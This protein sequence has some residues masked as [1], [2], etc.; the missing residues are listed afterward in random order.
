MLFKLKMFKGWFGE[1]KTSL[2]LWFTL[3]KKITRGFPIS[4]FHPEM[5]L[6]SWTI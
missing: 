6:P 4:L 2:N 5:E 3:V 1:Q